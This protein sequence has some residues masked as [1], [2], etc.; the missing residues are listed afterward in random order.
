MVEVDG[1]R[2]KRRVLSEDFKC[3]KTASQPCCEGCT[4][5]QK[6]D[7]FGSL[8]TTYCFLP[9]SSTSP[10]LDPLLVPLQHPSNGFTKLDFPKTMKTITRSIY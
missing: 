3:E 10:Q 1:A 8:H 4:V 5:S 9:Y 7:L 6:N 2:G